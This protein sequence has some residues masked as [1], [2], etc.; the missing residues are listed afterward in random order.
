MSSF[1]E[2]VV[3]EA[4]L[5]WFASFGYDVLAGVHPAACT[6]RVVVVEP[7]LPSDVAPELT[8]PRLLEARPQ[9]PAG[10]RAVDGAEARCGSGVGSGSRPPDTLPAVPAANH[11]YDRGILYGRPYRKIRDFPAGFGA[12]ALKPPL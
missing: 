1:T 5:E 6:D 9:S 11:R 8:A 7:L 10:R 3:E 4:A 12:F 2:T